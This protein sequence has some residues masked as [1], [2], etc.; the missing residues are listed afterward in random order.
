MLQADA[1]A[2]DA[3]IQKRTTVIT[4]ALLIAFFSIALAF[5]F[6]IYS[7]MNK[8]YSL[9]LE[10]EV[11]D[12]IQDIRISN[13]ELEKSNSELESFASISSGVG[14]QDTTIAVNNTAA[15]K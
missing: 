15:K 12:R 9:R 2:Y 1:E 11:D 6:Y 8:R 13:L 5:M 3:Q 14:P 7:R 4:V 10:R